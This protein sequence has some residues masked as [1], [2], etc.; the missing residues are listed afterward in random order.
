MGRKSIIRPKRE[1]RLSRSTRLLVEQLEDRL[2]PASIN[3]A[4]GLDSSGNLITVGGT[5]DANWTVD[6]LV[7]GPQPAQVTTPSNP[8]WYTGTPWDPNGP[9]SDWIT[10]DANNVN[11][12][13]APYSYYRFFTL[14]AAD[15]ATA[16]ITGAFTGDDTVV[17]TLNGHALGS[18]SIDNWGHL[19]PF[20]VPTG[21]PDFVVGLNE[22]TI[23]M[24]FA[25]DYIEGVR[26]EGTLSGIAGGETPPPPGPSLDWD[27]GHISSGTGSGGSGTL[28]N[29]DN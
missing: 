25:D 17:L 22:L 4:T 3:L 24:T 1:K 9:N 19:T 18:T 29:L 2:A 10:R 7:G 20:S 11:Q 27:P 23:N 6:E 13:P 28:N 15:L 16:T 26:L 12:G 8:V 14:N 5:P 21:S